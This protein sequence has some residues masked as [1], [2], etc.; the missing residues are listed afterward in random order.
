MEKRQFEK[1]LSVSDLA[2]CI[3]FHPET[4][5]KMARDGRLPHIK[6]SNRLRFRSDEID[7]WLRQREI[8]S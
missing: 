3:R 7:L 2:E 4:I 1:L 5:R 6:V 8:G